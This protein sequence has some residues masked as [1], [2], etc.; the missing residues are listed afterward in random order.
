MF[1]FEIKNYHSPLGEN[2][3]VAKHIHIGNDLQ[4]F[5]C[6]TSGEEKLA[7]PVVNKIIDSL[8]DTIHEA[9]VYDSLSVALEQ[10]NFFLK[11]FLDDSQEPDL[12]VIIG[13]VDGKTL[14]FSKIGYA[15]CTMINR[16]KEYINISDSEEV[17]WLFETI[18]SGEMHPYEIFFFGSHDLR[19][20]VT[21]SDWKDMYHPE[22]E[23]SYILEDVGH[24]L[25][26]EK[27]P[28]NS[29]LIAF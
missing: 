3:S 18:S 5:V 6:C 21:V 1:H 28:Y 23:L 20:V 12:D 8:L 22:D 24:I 13:V 14:H 17:T 27:F 2:A 19:N 11:T 16:K 29:S 26:D 10:I 25:K 9:N 7:T 4:C 15:T